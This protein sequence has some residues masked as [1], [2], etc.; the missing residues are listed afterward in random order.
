MTV[1][2]VEIW[3][4]MAKKYILAFDREIKKRVPHT[5]DSQGYAK[6]MVTGNKFKYKPTK[7]RK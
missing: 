2:V 5:I 3:V 1:N 6:S 7:K 4:K